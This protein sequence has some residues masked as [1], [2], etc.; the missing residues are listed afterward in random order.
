M[1]KTSF[2]IEIIIHDDA[3]TDSTQDIIRE[4]ANKDNR[5]IPIL[6]EQNIKSTGVAVFPITFQKA[7]GKYIALCEGDDYWTDPLK[8][9]K[10][11]D[12]LEAN[13]DFSGCTHM[14]EIKYIEGGQKTVR[15]KG[16]SAI[17][18]GYYL[19][20]N[21][22]MTTGSLL[23]KSKIVKNYP[24]WAKDLFAGDFV[25]KYLILADG[26]IK[27]FD[28]KMSV[29]RKGV[30][31]SWSKE[32]L[33]Q[34]KIDK[35]YFDNVLALHKINELTNYKNNYEVIIK[36]K[37]LFNSY[38]ARSI[39]ANIGANKIKL[40]LSNIIYFRKNDYKIIFHKIYKE[41]I[42]RYF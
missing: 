9:Q 25:L 40:F 26:K 32:L 42:A 35:E 27:Y 18:F 23:F 21:I 3:S 6:R 17:D 1:Q 29:Y 37:K 36:N 41:L 34:K 22:F 39:V 28:E 31:G 5:I 30:P 16:K 38:L 33:N 13:P 20:K 12:F 14:C 15:H 2:P 7:R 8:L 10:Q 19:K 24:D 11:V 4:Y